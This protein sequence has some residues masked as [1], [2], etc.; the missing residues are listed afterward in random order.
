[1]EIEKIDPLANI[2]RNKLEVRPFG[3]IHSFDPHR[4]EEV[5]ILNKE[6]KKGLYE[7]FLLSGMFSF[8]FFI[9]I[10]ASIFSCGVLVAIIFSGIIINNLKFL[11]EQK[12]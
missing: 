8:F 11:Y 3:I 6:F 12:K 9:S 10:G 1:M 5:G 7:Y 2:D 4:N